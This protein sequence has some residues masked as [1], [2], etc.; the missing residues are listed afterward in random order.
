MA[1]IVKGLLIAGGIVSG[2]SLVGS[3][4]LTLVSPLSEFEEIGDNPAGFAIGLLGL[5]VIVGRI[6]IYLL[7][8]ITFLICRRYLG[9]QH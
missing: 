1:R 3:G 7:T 5:A 2:L 8:A 9:T 6:L 4:L